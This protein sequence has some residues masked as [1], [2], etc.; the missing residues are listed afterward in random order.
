[1]SVLQLVVQTLI[2]TP[3]GLSFLEVRILQRL[4]IVTIVYELLI[5]ICIFVLNF[6]WNRGAITRFL[7]RLGPKSRFVVSLRRIFVRRHRCCRFS[8]YSW[9]SVV[10][11][12]RIV[13]S[14]D[15]FVL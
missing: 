3:R 10:V 6:I 2:L 5:F 13:V 7:A 9:V 15:C 14:L 11:F 8:L 4:L 12:L 1:M